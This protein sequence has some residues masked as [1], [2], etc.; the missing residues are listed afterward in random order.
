MN[1]L[2]LLSTTLI[3]FQQILV[4][5][6]LLMNQEIFSVQSLVTINF[7]LSCTLLKPLTINFQQTHRVN[8]SVFEIQNLIASEDY[9]EI[10]PVGSQ[11]MDLL[12]ENFWWSYEQTLRHTG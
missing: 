8:E 3:S 4:Y 6:P 5:C 1:N 11:T 9:D 2:K 7:A 10:M 12:P